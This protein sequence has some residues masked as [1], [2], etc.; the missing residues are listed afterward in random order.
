[1]QCTNENTGAPESGCSAYQVLKQQ[2][3]DAYTSN[4]APTQ[5]LIHSPYLKK[6]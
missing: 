5:I 2:F 4:R 6:K 3:D 1:M